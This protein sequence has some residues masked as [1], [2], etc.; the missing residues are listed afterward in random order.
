[1]S[2][3]TD[4]RP[5]AHVSEPDPHGIVG[6]STESMTVIPGDIEGVTSYQAATSETASRQNLGI[7]EDTLQNDQAGNHGNNLHLETSRNKMGNLISKLATCLSLNQ[8]SNGNNT[9]AI[10]KLPHEAGHNP[11]TPGPEE[12]PSPTDSTTSLDVISGSAPLQNSVLWPY[13]SVRVTGEYCSDD[14]VP[15][16]R[17]RRPALYWE[18]WAEERCVAK[19]RTESCATADECSVGED[20]KGESSGPS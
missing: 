12:T 1:M 16:L 7:S 19:Q 17:I 2:V 8:L 10:I 5:Y 18:Y 9:A 20:G 11:M 15:P 14:N 13:T 3:T 4:H 6:M